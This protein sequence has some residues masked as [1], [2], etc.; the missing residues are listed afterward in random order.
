MVAWDKFR[1][2]ENGDFD[3]SDNKDEFGNLESREDLEDLDEELLF[4]F[5]DSLEGEEQFK[6]TFHYT[7]QKTSSFVFEKITRSHSPKFLQLIAKLSQGIHWV[8]VSDDLK[9]RPKIC[10]TCVDDSC[11]HVQQLVKL[12]TLD[13]DDKALSIEKIFEKSH[14]CEHQEE[15]WKFDNICVKCLVDTCDD[16]EINLPDHIVYLWDTKDL[17][18]YQKWLNNMSIAYGFDN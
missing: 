15:N 7:G 4:N 18:E 6:G 9:D 13:M 10:L 11:T 16:V 8:N 17:A 3:F 5:L 12:D 14:E 2:S 1:G